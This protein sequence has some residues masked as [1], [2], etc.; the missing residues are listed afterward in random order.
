MLNLGELLRVAL[1][2]TGC[3]SP[4]RYVHSAPLHNV[5]EEQKED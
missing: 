2:D 5:L 1:E 3:S 4:G